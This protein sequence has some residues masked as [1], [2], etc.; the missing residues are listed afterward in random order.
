MRN[1]G[2]WAVL[3]EPDK[4]TIER[5]TFTCNH[6]NAVVH[7][8]PKMDPLQQNKFRAMVAEKCRM[9][10]RHVCATCLG[11]MRCLPFEKKLDAYEAKMRLRAMTG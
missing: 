11:E 4:A 10:M 5:D 1:P 6:C 9:C 7:V 2:G 8:N 3:T